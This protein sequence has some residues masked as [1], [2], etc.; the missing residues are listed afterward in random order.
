MSWTAVQQHRLAVEK[1]ILERYFAGKIRWIDQTVLGATKVEIE[2][3]TNNNKKYT[4][5]L[6][7]PSDFPNSLP[8]LV[9]ASSPKPMP[10]E[11]DISAANHTIGRRDGMLKICHF[12]APRWNPEHTFYEIFIKGRVWLEAYEGYLGSGKNLDYYLGHMK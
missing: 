5:R 4:L 10:K 12:Y 2:M 8:N 11:W 9:V 7:V 6:Y 3:T 1:E